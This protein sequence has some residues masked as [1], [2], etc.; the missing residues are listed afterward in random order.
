M[1]CTEALGQASACVPKPT[2]VQETSILPTPQARRWPE[3]KRMV[4]EK[5][6]AMLRAF[7]ALEGVNAAGKVELKQLKACSPAAL[8]ARS[9]QGVTW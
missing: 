5:E 3:F 9:G 6:A 8:P 1:H 4:D 7:T 2:I